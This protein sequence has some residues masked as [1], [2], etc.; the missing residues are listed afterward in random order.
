MRR[1]ELAVDPKI[2]LVV[3]ATPNESNLPLG[4]AACDSRLTSESLGSR[5]AAP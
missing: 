3:I 2:D 4:V 5:R 1:K